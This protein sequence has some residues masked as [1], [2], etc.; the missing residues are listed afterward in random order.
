MLLEPNQ[1][2][3]ETGHT[4]SSLLGECLC[5][6]LNANGDNDIVFASG[7]TYIATQGA[8]GSLINNHLGEWIHVAFTINDKT[9]V[10]KFYVNGVDPNDEYD[11][12]TYF[13]TTNQVN[14]D[15]PNNL[16][17]GKPDPAQNVNRSSFDGS[18]ENVMIFNRA[19]SPSEIQAVYSDTKPH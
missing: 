4:I 14:F 17:L 3:S 6:T 8:G 9:K 1:E 5:D 19:L 15:L 7:Y 18:M 13:N 2:I 11:Y 12:G 16:Y 10:A